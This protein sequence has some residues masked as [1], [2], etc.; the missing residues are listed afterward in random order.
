MLKVDYDDHKNLR[1]QY[2]V[3]SQTSYVYVDPDGAKRAGRVGSMS[4]GHVL[5]QIEKA[6]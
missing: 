4:I 2:D 6:K 3:R 5:E 1:T